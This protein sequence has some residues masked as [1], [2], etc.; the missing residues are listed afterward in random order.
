MAIEHEDHRDGLGELPYDRRRVRRETYDREPPPS[1]LPG[2][3]QGFRGP[4]T[5]PQPPTMPGPAD[6]ASA[7]SAFQSTLGAPAVEAPGICYGVDVTW[8]AR[9]VNAQDWRW[10]ESLDFTARPGEAPN[11]PTRIATFTVPDGWIGILR[12]VQIQ[13]EI[14][15]FVENAATKVDPDFSDEDNPFGELPYLL[16]I[17]AAG[18]V[19][20]GFSQP[21]SSTGALAD[22]P[23]AF[24][25]MFDS[26]LWALADE[27]R[28]FEVVITQNTDTAVELQPLA[29]RHVHVT[30]WGTL[31][32]RR[33]REIQYEPANV[34]SLDECDASAAMGSTAPQREQPLSVPRMAKEGVRFNPDWAPTGGEQ[35]RAHMAYRRWIGQKYSPDEIEAYKSWY[36]AMRKRGKIPAEFVEQNFPSAA[37]LHD[38]TKPRLQAPQ[39]GTR[40]SA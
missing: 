33:G 10:L 21:L 22:R 29:N 1:N 16:F 32:Q 28:T 35:L 14:G 12:R 36:R 9:P 24:S 38:R 31:L 39:V 17:R 3:A 25:W 30:M 11:P 23:I 18:S 19:L 13:P 8:N 26:E 34:Q 6:V 15:F 7:D 20:P 4:G 5:L 2:G 40:G 27:Q 37:E